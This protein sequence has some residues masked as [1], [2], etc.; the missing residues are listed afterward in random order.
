MKK[1]ATFLATVGLFGVTAPADAHYYGGCKKNK[2]KRHVVKP[3]RGWLANTRACEVR[4]QPHP[5][6]TATGNGFF[7]AYQFTMQTWFSVGGWG[8]PNRASKTE[9]DYRAVK[10]LFSQGRGA[11]PICG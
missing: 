9:Q 11:W 3:Y 2:C 1:L 4:G 5:Y 7:G 6:A 8:M 10:V